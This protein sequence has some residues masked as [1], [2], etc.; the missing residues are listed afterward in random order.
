MKI[1]KSQIIIISNE[2]NKMT[3]NNKNVMIIIKSQIIIIIFVKLMSNF[4]LRHQASYSYIIRHP[5]SSFSLFS[6]LLII[7]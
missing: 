5:P 4:F 3:K 7:G 1:I 2:N 6:P